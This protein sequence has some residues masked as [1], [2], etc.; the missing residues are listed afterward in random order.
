M[1]LKQRIAPEDRGLALHN[2]RKL[3]NWGLAETAN[4]LGIST[5]TLTSHENG[6]QPVPEAR[7]RLFVH[8]IGEV[9]RTG[10]YPSGLVI[11]NGEDGL[12]CIDVVSSDNYAGIAVSDDGKS[13]LIASYAFDRQTG[14]PY[15]HRVQFNVEVNSH[16]FKVVEKW[17]EVRRSQAPDE[18]VYHA[19]RWIMRCALKGEIE[20]PEMAELKRAMN[21]ANER[22]NASEDATPEEKA[23]LF[24]EHEAAVAAFVKGLAAGRSKR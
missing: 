7:W 15:L 18:A 6:T 8:E 20:H 9:L 21:D 11:V 1:T 2:W 4:R 16:V 5:R 22:L 12:S 24:D 14:A 10:K 17:E 23:R 3:L 19:Q 13:G